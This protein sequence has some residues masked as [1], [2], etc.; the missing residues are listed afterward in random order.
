MSHIA[1]SVATRMASSSRMRSPWSLSRSSRYMSSQYFGEDTVQ[2]RFD[3]IPGHDHGSA[4]NNSSR[5][6]KLVLCHGLF[7]SKQNFRSLARQFAK[8]L[9]MDVYSVDL[10]NHGASPHSSTM[11]YQAM[12]ADLL[13][14]LHSIHSSDT[15]ITL[16]GHSMG[17]KVAM[18]LAL[19]PQTP[20]DLLRN[21]IV[22][23][24]SPIKGKLSKEFEGYARTMRRIMDMG[25]KTRN[26]ADA[27][28][29]ESEPDLTVRQFLLTNVSASSTPDSTLSFRV[30][31]DIIADSMENLGD[32]PFAMEDNRKFANP[33]LVIRGA[34]SNYIKDG[35]IPVFSYFFPNHELV[36][37]NTGHWVHAEDPATFTKCVI[38]FIQRTK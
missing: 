15:D 33:T 18:A 24:I 19:H 35:A 2:L 38:D 21:L 3:H 1:R 25:L 12:A 8:I 34:K 4:Q 29:Q 14:F 23:D 37:L 20:S 27:V 13:R 6:G 9:G 32:F 7:G 10:R 28:L 31:P 26:E 5:K 22:E 11:T 17:G 36:T 30:P 16:L